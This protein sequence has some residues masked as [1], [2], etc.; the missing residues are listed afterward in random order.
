VEAP[1]FFCED[2]VGSFEQ[3]LHRFTIKNIMEEVAVPS[4]NFAVWAA[5]PIL[6]VRA[7]T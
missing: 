2:R 6:R 3:L 4:G 7:Y 5:R 1:A